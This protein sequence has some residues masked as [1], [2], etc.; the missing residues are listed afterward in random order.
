MNNYDYG[1]LVRISGTFMDKEAGDAPV[2]PTTVTLTIR[3]PGGATIAKS[4][5]ADITKDSVGSYHYDI[6]LD[7]VGL[8]YYRWS[9]T[10]VGQAAEEGCFM[11]RKSEVL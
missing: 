4:F 9:S 5:P 8:W 7:A 3:K 6:G 10:G 11:V 1:D 2:D